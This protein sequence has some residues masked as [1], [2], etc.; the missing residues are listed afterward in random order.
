[1]EL[2]E[3]KESII[4]DEELKI[5]EEGEHDYYRTL[6]K[7]ALENIVVSNK[8]DVIETLIPLCE[9]LYMDGLTDGNY[10]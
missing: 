5:I 10:K 7:K 2:T 8:E 6:L 4:T 3:L 1:M 9:R